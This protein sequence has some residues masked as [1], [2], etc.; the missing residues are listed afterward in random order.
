MTMRQ[1][2]V[3]LLLTVCIRGTAQLL[4]AEDPVLDQE[5]YFISYEQDTIYGE[6]RYARGLLN[7]GIKKIYFIDMDGVK[8]TLRAKQSSGFMLNGKS[9]TSKV[10]DEIHYFLR[11]A[12]TGTPALF[13]LEKSYA[14]KE[15]NSL[16]MLRTQNVEM[17]VLDQY[18][19]LQ[20]NVHKLYERRFQK[21]APRLFA[22]YPDVVE[23]IQSGEYTFADIEEIVE[24]C[25]YRNDGVARVKDE[26]SE[27]NMK[28]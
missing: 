18:I 5:S 15:I 13:V 20:G 24:W 23:K 17:K 6:V 16:A 25:N 26:F 22:S 8:H 21:Q 3:L 12:V 27:K 11:P 9:Y 10:I 1:L 28:P 14:K 19:E 4:G 2:L 7:N